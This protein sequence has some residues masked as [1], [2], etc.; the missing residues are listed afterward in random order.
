MTST[1]TR[2]DDRVV[3]RGVP[4]AGDLDGL[5][6]APRPRSTVWLSLVVAATALGLLVLAFAYNAARV[7]QV[8][9]RQLFWVALVMLFAP[10]AVALVHPAPSRDQRI[11]LILLLALGSYGIKLLFS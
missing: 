10:P 11:L 5:S 2:V 9:A 4:S 7:E 6:V 8:G 1:A 3:E